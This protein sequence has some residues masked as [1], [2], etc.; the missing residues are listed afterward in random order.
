M[1]FWKKKKQRDSV[2]IQIGDK[3][4]S[5]DLKDEMFACDLKAC[6]GACCVEGD[7]GAPVEKEEIEILQ[8]IYPKVKPYLRPE[9]IAVIEAEGTTV[10]DIT[11]SFST[12]LVK[13]RECAYVTFAEDGTALCGIE[14]AWQDGVIDFQKPISCHL[15][16]VRITELKDFD[17]LNYDRWSI[18]SAACSLGEKMGI[19]VYQFVK[20][21]LIRKYGLEFYEELEAVLKGLDQ[22]ESDSNP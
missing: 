14:Q 15:Y 22:P 11:N 3:L 2:A 4:V 6:K 7:L 5:S 9:G 18:C 8:E 20:D 21:A 12:P 16:P 17:A 19:P 1:S 13:G 10:L